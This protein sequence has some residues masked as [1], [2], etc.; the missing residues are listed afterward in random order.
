LGFPS[1]PS[2]NPCQVFA[3]AA[4]CRFEPFQGPGRRKCRKWR[5]F[6]PTPTRS[7]CSYMGSSSKSG[8]RM[9]ACSVFVPYNA[10]FSRAKL[11]MFSPAPL[12]PTGARSLQWA[13]PLPQASATASSSGRAARIAANRMVKPATMNRDVFSGEQGINSRERA[14]W[15]DGTAISASVRPRDAEA[16]PSG[17]TR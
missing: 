11:R 7:R 9:H 10:K 17:S 1:A 12:I 14:V 4:R 8:D 15:R 6:A 2:P 3:I 16:V 13:P 5:K